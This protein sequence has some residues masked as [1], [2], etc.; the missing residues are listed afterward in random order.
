MKNKPLWI[1]RGI[2]ST[3][4]TQTEEQQMSPRTSSTQLI[5]APQKLVLIILLLSGLVSGCSTAK[6]DTPAVGNIETSQTAGADVLTPAPEGL[7]STE[8]QT[9]SNDAAEFF[10][11]DQL[12]LCF[13]YP[14]GYTQIPYENSVEIVATE[15]PASGTNGV[16]WL[17]ISDSYDR[18]ALRIADEDMT[19]AFPEGGSPA[20]I[21]WWSITL[22]GEE[23]VVLDGMP[24]QDL[25]RRVYAVHDQTLY[26]LA[27]MPTRSGNKAVD[28]Q[29]EALY[30]A[31]TRSW[32]WS[33]C[34]GIE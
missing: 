26:I 7:E 17:E 29:M 13:F 24:G 8:D 34:S 16:F 19:L 11:S 32:S 12:G 18:T 31:I 25:Q 20:N 22:D 9:G 33:A 2:L 30:T 4:P 23:A 5:L 10:S 1:M 15:H 27:F 3:A 21:D 14:Q 6:P 28:D